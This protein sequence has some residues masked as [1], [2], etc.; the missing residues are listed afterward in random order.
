MN[1]TKDIESFGRIV[2]NIFFF[3]VDY[4]KLLV[5]RE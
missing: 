4:I 5:V 3:M 1:L 2:Y